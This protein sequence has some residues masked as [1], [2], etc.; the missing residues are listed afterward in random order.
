ME[1]WNDL[2]DSEMQFILF[3]NQ[4]FLSYKI[5]FEKDIQDRSILVFYIYELQ[6]MIEWQRKG[7]GTR[8]LD[9]A[10]MRALNYNK[11]N[12]DQSDDSNR[13]DKTIKK[14]MLTCHLNNKLAL[15]FYRKHEFID[16]EISP[17]RVMGTKKAIKYHGYTIMSRNLL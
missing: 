4:G 10:V 14:L 6:V 7:I 5:C 13:T 8:L 2:N 3:P 17:T 15:S 1:K 11:V 12:N 16:D 9:E